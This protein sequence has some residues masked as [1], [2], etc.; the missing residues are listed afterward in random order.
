MPVF[1][2]AQ[3]ASFLLCTLNSFQG[4]LKTGS[5][6]FNPCRGRCQVP[7]CSWQKE[8]NSG[9][10]SYSLA[11]L[12]QYKSITVYPLWTWHSYIPL[13]IHLPLNKDNGKITHALYNQ[14]HALSLS[15]KGIQVLCPSLGD[16][17]LS[18]SWVMFLFDILWLKSWDVRLTTINTFYIRWSV[19]GGGKQKKTIGECIHKYIHIKIR[20]NTRNYQSC[21]WNWSDDH[22]LY[23]KYIFPLAI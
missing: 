11:K 18:S 6:W 16:V 17:D 13:L 1:P 21:F 2:Q 7:I 23:Y 15:Q 9:K 12:T 20:K 19:N 14:K 22:G 3:S 4:V 8:R 10:P 5:T